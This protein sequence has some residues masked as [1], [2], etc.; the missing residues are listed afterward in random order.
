M[1]NVV[2]SYGIMSKRCR[3]NDSVD[4]DQTAPEIRLLRPKKKSCVYCNMSGK[5]GSVGGIF[6]SF[7]QP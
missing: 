7:S 4:P 2:L 6:F 5:N 3:R 1:S